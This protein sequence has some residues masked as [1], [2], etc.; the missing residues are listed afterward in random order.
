MQKYTPK[1]KN[2]V[3]GIKPMHKKCK[4]NGLKHGVMLGSYCDCATGKALMEYHD[5][6]LDSL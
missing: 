6:L 2:L 1:I 4:G 3:D 5:L